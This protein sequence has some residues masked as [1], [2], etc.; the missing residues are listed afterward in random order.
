M[1][2]IG[3]LFYACCIIIPILYF[4]QDDKSFSY[5]AAFI[6]VINNLFGPDAAQ[7]FLGLPF[8]SILGF[9][10]FAIPL[11]LFYSYFSRFSLRRIDKG[12]RFRFEDDGIREVTWKNSFCLTVAGGIS[13]FFIDQF[14]HFHKSMMLWP[15]VNIS[16][17]EMLAWGGE[18]YHVF[19]PITIL[20]FTVILF[21][22]IFS[23][24]TFEKG[25]KES[26][27]LLLSVIGIA[28]IFILVFGGEV[29]GGEREL[30][31]IV[32]SLVYV[33][34]PLFLLFYV[35]RDIREHPNEKREIPK[36]DRNKLLNIIALI[37]CIFAGFWILFCSLIIISPDIMAVPLASRM[38]GDP[39]DFYNTLILAAVLI[40]LL[41]IPL[42]I[43][44]I[45]LFFRINYC[46]YIVI[47]L[48]LILFMLAF[49]MGISLFLCEKDVKELFIKDSDLT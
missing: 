9:L 33:L 42:L 11:S 2:S 49:P 29:Y 23:L 18:A 10:I 36:I 48:Y 40:L 47:G 7:I 8:H 21:L 45:G 14:Y 28:I 32:H 31:V 12:V 30:G 15:G 46:R 1:P 34:I 26:L 44:S 35:A 19:E 20:G 17:D 25:Y 6:F 4:T 37:S 5:K 24:H 41:T 13:H 3:H 43:C 16:H 39:S 22:M 27:I 38:G